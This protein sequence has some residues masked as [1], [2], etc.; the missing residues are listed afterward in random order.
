MT[1]I[2]CGGCGLTADLTVLH[3]QGGLPHQTNVDNVNMEDYA[4]SYRLAKERG[5][6]PAVILDCPYMKQTVDAA[7]LGGRI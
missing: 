3:P 1:Q 6:A 4:K 2:R 5:R 7:I